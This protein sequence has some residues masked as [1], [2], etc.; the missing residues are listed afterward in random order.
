[1][2]GCLERLSRSRLIEWLPVTAVSCTAL[3]FLLHILGTDPSS[4]KYV[5]ESIYSNLIKDRLQVLRT[6][7]ETYQFQYEGVNWIIE[8]I[9]R[10]VSLSRTASISPAGASI[11]GPNEQSSTDGEGWM[12]KLIFQ[13][14]WYLR[15]AF[16]VDVA[17]SKG[18]LPGDESFSRSFHE[19]V[20]SE[21]GQSR[22]VT[23]QAWAR[24]NPSDRFYCATRGVKDNQ[25]IA[26]SAKASS[27]GTQLGPEP[28]YVITEMKGPSWERL[29]F[30]NQEVDA[31][32]MERNG[33]DNSET[34]PSSPEDNM[35]INGEEKPGRDFDIFTLF[36]QEDFDG[37][38]DFPVGLLPT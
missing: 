9:N 38:A 34:M 24:D 28:S 35:T 7:M 19:L 23:K 6:A 15:L 5:K 20:L 25:S 17:L 22:D 4:S 1:M 11:L 8:V 26:G 14:S 32:K 21:A 3:P 37:S 12:G 27:E 36:T 18:Q 10:V 13:P 2:A 16:A 33:G 30:S 31:A 29:L